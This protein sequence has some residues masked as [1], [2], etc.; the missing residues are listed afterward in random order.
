MP[1]CHILTLLLLTMKTVEEKTVFT[2]V[3]TITCDSLHPSDFIQQVYLPHSVTSTSSGQVSSFF[4]EAR[5]ATGQITAKN[6]FMTSVCS[7]CISC[8]NQA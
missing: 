8:T 5:L 6:I 7:S 2:A 1:C 3:I 4:G